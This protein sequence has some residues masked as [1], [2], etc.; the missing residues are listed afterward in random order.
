[1]EDVIDVH[2][3]SLTSHLTYHKASTLIDIFI[4][5]NLEISGR[6]IVF[7]EKTFQDAT[8]GSV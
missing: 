7:M 3:T 1:V 5:L 6:L 2:Y 8:S 4:P